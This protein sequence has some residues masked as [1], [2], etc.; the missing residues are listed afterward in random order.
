M[1][2]FIGCKLCS[3]KILCRVGSCCSPAFFLARTTTTRMNALARGYGE[4]REEGLPVKVEV[5]VTPQIF[6]L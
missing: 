1:A 2:L 5:V 3:G 4:A 6:A